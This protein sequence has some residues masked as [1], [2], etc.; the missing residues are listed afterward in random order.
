MSTNLQTNPSLSSIE[1][2]LINKQKEVQNQLISIQKDDPMLIY[3]LPESHEL[4]TDSWQSEVH[5]R[6]SA[7][8]ESLS[9][10]SDNISRSLQKIKNGTYGKCDKCGNHIN[11]DRLKAMPLAS[12]CTL[13]L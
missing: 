9:S 3:D 5:D 8:R 13:C 4:G 10:L 2:Y 6:I 7:L 1:R 12:N 11:P